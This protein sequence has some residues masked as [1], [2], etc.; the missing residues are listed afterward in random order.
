M[1]YQD[2]TVGEVMASDPVT[3]RET[4]TIGEADAQ[5]HLADIRHLPVVDRAHELVGIVSDRDIF[6]GLSRGGDLRV[7]EVMSAEVLTVRPE[8][9]ACEATLLMLEHKI[10]ALPVLEAGGRRLAGMVTE[11]D[12]VRIAHV[13]LGGDRLSIDEK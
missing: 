5:M 8:T 10:G 3:L 2:L 13:V 12:F 9:P 7:S 1:R 4:D 6:R 11:T